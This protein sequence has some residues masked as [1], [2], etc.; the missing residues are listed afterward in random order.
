M[1]DWDLG[2]GG[3]RGDEGW[4]FNVYIYFMLFNTEILAKLSGVKSVVRVRL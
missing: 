4:F 2:M 3:S 1:I